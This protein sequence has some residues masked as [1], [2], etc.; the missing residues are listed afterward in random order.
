MECERYMIR[1]L[2]FL[3]LVLESQL[4]PFKV[5]RNPASY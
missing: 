4:P 3:F 5:L 1:Q 2:S